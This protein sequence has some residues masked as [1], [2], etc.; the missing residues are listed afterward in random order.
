MTG[1]LP[2]TDPTGRRRREVARGLGAAVVLFCFIVGVPAAL[3]ALAPSY[4]PTG[5]AGPLDAW[6]LLASPDDG[7][8]LFAVVAAIAWLCWAVF[9]ASVVLEFVASARRV[10]APRLR[11]VGGIQTLASRLVATAGVLLAVSTTAV[12]HAAPATA[13]A[14]T[15][16]ATHDIEPAPSN[17]GS[18]AGHPNV[19]EVGPRDSGA[20]LPTITVQRGDTL[21]GI[22]ERHLGSGAR[23]TEIRDLNLRRPQPDGQ[24]LVGADWINPG[25]TLRLP[26]DATGVEP[27]AAAPLDARQTVTVER[28]DT[29]W[30]I[31]ER[32]LGDGARFVELVELNRGRMQPDGARLEDPDLIR[33]GWNLVLPATAVAPAAPPVPAPSRVGPLE[34]ED[35]P[36]ATHAPR[37]AL[38]AP[39]L[40]DEPHASVTPREVPTTDVDGEVA[41]ED[42]DT[43][44]HWY[45]G[46]AGL[47]AAG[48]VAEIT[49]RRRLQQRARR[50]GETIPMPE[51]GSPASRAERELRAAAPEVIGIE[52]IVATLSRL[53]HTYDDKGIDLPRVAAVLLRP[54]RL[55]IVLSDDGPEPEQPFERVDARTWDAPASALA[56]GPDP[57]DDGWVPYPML[58]VLGHSDDETTVVVN[59]EAAGTLTIAGDPATCEETLRALTVELATSPLAGRLTVLVDDE[60]RDLTGAFEAHRLRAADDQSPDRQVTMI[61]RFLA[62]IGCDDTLQA[63]AEHRADDA[64]LPVAFLGSAHDGTPAP[65]SGAVLITAGEARDGWTLDVQPD[66]IA[67]LEPLGIQLHVQRLSDQNL[68]A[69]RSLLQTALPPTPAQP[70]TTPPVPV[71][72]DLDALRDVYPQPEPEAK[73]ID[74]NRV[75]VR[76]LGP[77]EIE[78]LPAGVGQL[79]PRVKELLVFLALHGPT[80]ATDL[81]D[82]LWNGARV[83]PHTRNMLIYR[84]R[85]AVGEEILPRRDD[86]RYGLTETVTTDWALFQGRV[87]AAVNEVD[88]QER[89]RLLAAALELVQERPLRGLGGAEYPWA[90]LDIQMMSSAVADAALVHAQFLHQS[91]RSREAIEAAIRGLRAEP[92]SERLQALLLEATESAAGREEAGRLRLSFAEAALALDD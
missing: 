39:S 19:A 73:P 52:A 71:G 79:R 81:D 84:A 72:T 41:P 28:G 91:G 48:V 12:A 1:T 74:G 44:A 50:L 43:Q 89:E 75:V 35:A 24:S 62:R 92:Y 64:W 4:T 21:W 36:Q 61:A 59:L 3:V 17:V 9:T 30:K 10:T 86:G 65:W 66:G 54:D 18:P 34:V 45:L 78:G 46:L 69:L 7:T 5:V 77:V 63:R 40:E 42:T 22:A 2:A 38:P 76:V 51:A 53:G 58:V 20:D 60:H 70:A 26:A 11:L 67:L 57:T 6:E 88:A 68:D 90:D 25:W 33:P 82:V 37:P 83:N 56:T 55:R 80:T 32:H 87:G 27:A 31:A 14:H 47:A 15:R 85:Q 29:L 8:L 49:R 16:S 13:I 23:Y